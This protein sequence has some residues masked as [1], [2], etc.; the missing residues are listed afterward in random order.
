MAIEMRGGTAGRLTVRVAAGG[1][2]KW[3]EVPF[4]IA[5]SMLYE[6]I[7]ASVMIG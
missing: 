3:E 5:G 7:R 6:L 1:F 2:E 4:N